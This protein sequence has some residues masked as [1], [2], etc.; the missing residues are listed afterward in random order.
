MKSVRYIVSG[1][2]DEVKVDIYRQ[3]SGIICYW[4]ARD[5][6]LSMFPISFSDI[7]DI[8]DDEVN[9]EIS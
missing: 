3:V 2:S 6:L 1:M 5:N 7:K 4:H 8:I 9:D